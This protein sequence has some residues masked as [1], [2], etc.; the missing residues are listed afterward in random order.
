MLKVI[1]LSAIKKMVYS[2]GLRAVAESLTFSSGMQRADK[3]LSSI[4][5][6]DAWIRLRGPNCPKKDCS[7]KVVTRIIPAEIMQVLPFILLIR[8]QN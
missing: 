7:L 6:P 5:Y 1:L 2:G 8:Q 3:R 4:L